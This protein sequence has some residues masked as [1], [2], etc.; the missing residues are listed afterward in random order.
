MYS[1]N[2]VTVD[3]LRQYVCRRSLFT[4]VLLNAFHQV[5]KNWISYD[6]KKK[7]F[8]SGMLGHK[9]LVLYFENSSHVVP[10]IRV[11]NVVLST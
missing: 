1:E 4:F 3:G 7:P 2:I 11:Y 10:V 5:Y 6:R 8:K 9:Q